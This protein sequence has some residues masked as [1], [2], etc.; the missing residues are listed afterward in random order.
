MRKGDDSPEMQANS[1]GFKAE[2]CTE[3]LTSATAGI[4][5]AVD[6]PANE[7]YN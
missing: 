6:L 7:G 1:A 3:L 2:L 5:Q 4:E